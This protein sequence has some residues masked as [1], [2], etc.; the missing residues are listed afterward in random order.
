MTP[1]IQGLEVIIIE[2]D[3]GYARLAAKNIRRKQLSDHITQFTNG[4]DALAYLQDT[5]ATDNPRS[6]LILLDINMP[7]MDGFSILEQLKAAP[8]T[9]SIPVIMLSSVETQ[10]KVVRCYE[11]GCSLFV[12][13]PEHYSDLGEVIERISKLLHIAQLPY[14]V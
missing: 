9:R 10:A 13:K 8:G 12:T 2:D 4:T 7:G 6:R 3:S 14:A 1:P 5:S 11:L